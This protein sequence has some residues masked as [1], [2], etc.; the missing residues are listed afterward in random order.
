MEE[1]EQEDG[2][3]HQIHREEVEPYP[4]RGHETVKDEQS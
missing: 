3:P 4:Q 2:E 1:G